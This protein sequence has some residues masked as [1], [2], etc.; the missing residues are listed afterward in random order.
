[1]F[2]NRFIKQLHSD[3]ERLNSGKDN[4]RSI[5]SSFIFPTANV[6]HPEILIAGKEISATHYF[7]FSL[8]SVFAEELKDPSNA[9]SHECQFFDFGFISNPTIKDE[10]KTVAEG[11]EVGLIDLPAHTC[12]ME[13]QW[14]D[15]TGPVTSGYLFMRDDNG[16]YGSE[17]RL[18]SRAALM[19]KQ[20]EISGRKVRMTE[21]LS[22]KEYF[23]WDGVIL[24]LPAEASS[25]GYEAGVICNTANQKPS[26]NNLFD[27]LMSMLGRL[28][29]DGIEQIREPAPERLNRR[30]EAKGL[31]GVV[32]YTEVKIR[33]H[34][35]ALG[36]SGPQSGDYTPKKYHFRRGHVRHFAN[37]EKTWVRNCFVGDPTDGIVKHIYKIET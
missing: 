20:F 26:P 6:D 18:L 32:S 9:F 37:G 7:Y 34:R 21:K 2:V 35:A 12:W 15:V 13:H 28:N 10:S 29:A 3:I 5:L 19:E 24:H 33:P 25:K 27:P 1:M 14:N 8:T 31:P 17:I 23:V 22:S 36:H 30:R 4:Y 11:Y 16:I